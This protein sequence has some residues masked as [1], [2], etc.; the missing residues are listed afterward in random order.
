MAVRVVFYKVKGDFVQIFY[1]FLPGGHIFT[2]FLLESGPE[3]E[4]LYCYQSK[5]S[6]QYHGSKTK[7]YLSK[8]SNN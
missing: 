8:Q 5:E 7:F 2:H 6:E 3:T 4:E 1:W